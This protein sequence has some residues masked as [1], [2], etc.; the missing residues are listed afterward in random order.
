MQSFTFQTLPKTVDELKAYPL[1]TPHAAA[2]LYVLAM[3]AYVE[4]TQVGLDMI[5]YLKGPV[6]LSNYDK[7]FIRDRLADKP[8]LPYSYFNGATP[9]NNYTPA[10]PYVIEVHDWVYSMEQGYTKV[11]LQSGGADSKRPV[12]LRQK[13]NEHF[14]WEDGGLMMGIRIP[15]K[16]DPWA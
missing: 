4:N 3:C 12:I 15:V 16:D 8:Y 1:S 11:F 5:D 7:Q 9:Q 6:Q 2:A 13:G 14:V 10:Q